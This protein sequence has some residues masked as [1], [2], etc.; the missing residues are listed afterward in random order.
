MRRRICGR[1]YLSR[2]KVFRCIFFKSCV[3]FFKKDNQGFF[4]HLFQADETT[5]AWTG[6]KLKEFG[7][8]S[9]VGAHCTGAHATRR[10]ADI[11]ELE[12]SAVSMGAIGTRID[13]KLGITPSSIE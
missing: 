11:L 12:R 5:I 3:E 4:F 10:L 8:Q 1:S 2:S 6:N 7:V 9:F 13:G